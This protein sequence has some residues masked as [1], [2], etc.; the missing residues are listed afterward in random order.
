M[1]LFPKNL[2][3]DLHTASEKADENGKHEKSD[4]ANGSHKPCESLMEVEVGST[5]SQSTDFVSTIKRHLKNK[6]FVLRTI[7]SIFHL[8]PLTGIC[9]FLPRYLET[10][11]L[12]QP[13]QATFFSGTFGILAM[14][15]GI[16]I[17]GI[18]SAKYQLTAKKWSHWVVI[19]TSLTALGMLLLMVIGCEMD[20]YKGLVIKEGSR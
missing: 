12:M 4:E 13:N 9:I 14:G 1:F 10:Q 20:N 8:I 5:S 3:N 18:I 15:F 7:S 16:S 19:S 17:T 2:H 11:F 6:I